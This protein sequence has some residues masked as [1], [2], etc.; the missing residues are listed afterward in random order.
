MDNTDRVLDWAPHHDPRSKAFPVRAL[1]ET[2]PKRRNKLWK[3]GEVLDQGREG[4]CV[5]FGWT[6]EARSTPVAVD[7]S[8]VAA[9]V[10]RDATEFA[11]AIYR[12][13]QQIDE[14]EGETYSGTSVNAGA[15]AMREVGLVNEYRWAFSIDD[16]VN[17]ILVKGPVVLGI[18]WRY[19]MYWTK[20]D[21]VDATGNVVG[22]HCLTAVGYSLKSEKLNGEDGIILQNSWGPSW[23]NNGLALIK[24]TQLEELLNKNGEAAVA[25]KRS[26]GRTLPKK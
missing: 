12:R 6:S 18:E 1:I 15:K 4:A 8:R 10:P 26:Y 24:V 7:L 20:N 17:T 3:V 2:P 13:A 21:V 5:G 19:N 9:E 23:G 16:V 25:T 22:G 11:L 14:W